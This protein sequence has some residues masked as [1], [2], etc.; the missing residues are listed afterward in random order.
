MSDPVLYQVSA[1]KVQT[2]LDCP[3]KF[4]FTYVGRV[5]VSVAW[6]HLTMGI[7]L[8]NALRD[9][10]DVTPVDRTAGT[11]EHLL[12]RHWSDAG[13]R[14]RQQAQQWQRSATA[15]LTAY[16]HGLD[17]HFSPVSVERTLAFRADGIA[18]TTRI[19]RLDPQPGSDSLVVVDYKTGKRIPGQDDVRGSLAL[20]LYALSVQR[21]LRRPCSRVELH[22][23]PSSAIAG[24]EHSEHALDRQLR[25]VQDVAAEMRAAQ[26]GA[27]TGEAADQDAF[28]PRPGP[29]CGW[30]DYL[31]MCQPGLR[32]A[33]P[34]PSWAGLP[35]A[36]DDLEAL[37]LDDGRSD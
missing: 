29:L 5:R 17:P 25:R 18:V 1:S 20:A 9:W 36:P 33:S 14:D 4:W 8:H 6:A 37:E 16:L 21:A 22:H 13:F 19:D 11:A 12:D 15:M 32:A 10:W 34:Q 3:R 7:A 31:S 28:E 26:R 35:Q 24:W 30:C 23:V 2:W 27:V